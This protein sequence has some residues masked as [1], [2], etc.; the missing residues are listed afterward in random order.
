MFVGQFTDTFLPVV[1]GVGRVVYSY[2]RHLGQRCERCYVITPISEAYYGGQPFETLEYIA[3]PLS[4]QKQYSTGMPRLDSHYYRKLKNIPFDIVHAHSPFV[5]GAEAK[6]VAKKLGIPLVATFHSKYKDDFYQITKSEQLSK[7]GMKFV[8]DFYRSC[9]DVWAVSESS[10]QVLREYGYT[11]N[12]TV[13]ENGTEFLTARPG[14]RQAVRERLQAK[15]RFLFL[16]VGQMNWKKNLHRILNSLHLL[17][18]K[19]TDFLLVMAGQGPAEEEIAQEVARLGLTGHV[20]FAGHITKQEDLAALYAAA[21][22][23]VFPSEYDNAPMVVREA[24]TL[25][26]PSVLLSGSCAAEVVTNGVNGFLTENTDQS[27][28]N[29]LLHLMEH[30]EKLASA[31]EQ[32]RSTI[33]QPWEHIIDKVVKRYASLIESKTGLPHGKHKRTF[34]L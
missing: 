2:A 8:L 22:V 24:A 12:I 20:R 26:L 7:I 1:D 21:D 3:H 13:M 4:G 31:G 33:A 6:K 9:D 34:A 11:G 27:M 19:R 10:G 14:D 29:L 28:A 16:Y 18:R 32:A 30:P 25:G 23:F 5:A 15:D 17:K